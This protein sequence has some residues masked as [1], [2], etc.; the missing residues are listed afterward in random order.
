MVVPPQKQT[1]DRRLT[2]PRPY[3][4][5]FIRYLLAPLGGLSTAM[6]CTAVASHPD[7]HPSVPD[8]HTPPPGG[9]VRD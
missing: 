7:T 5:G 8:F 9:S 1:H 4:V 6:R 2:F 3:G